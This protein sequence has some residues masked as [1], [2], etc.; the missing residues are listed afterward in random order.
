MV[1][2]TRLRK[3]I[4]ILS[5]VSAITA[6]MFDFF[7]EA[8]LYAIF[9][10][11]TTVLILSLLFFVQR[12]NLSGFRNIMISALVFCLIGDIFLLRE[13]YFVL[14]LCSFLIGHVLFT[15]GFVKL[16]GFQFRW[17]SLIVLIGIGAGLFFWLRPGL[18]PFEL[19]VGIYVIVI[20]LMAWQGTSLFLKQGQ[21]AYALIGIAVLLFM[22]SDAIIA[23]NKFKSSIELG[24]LLILSTY[25]LSIGLISNATYL[26]LKKRD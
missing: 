26:I 14:G 8:L 24:G 12:T 4:N 2:E 25:W 11:L 21:K 19:P 9:K 6:I 16:G 18:G 15:T 20:V 23:I 10:P 3:I 13:E 22:F 1:N 5:A 17:T 7:N